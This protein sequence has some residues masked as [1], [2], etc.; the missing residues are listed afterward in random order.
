MSVHQQ[1]LSKIDS[2]CLDL[3]LHLRPDKCITL[4]FTDKRFD[5]KAHVDLL[6]GSTSNISNQPAKFL[7]KYIGSSRSSSL[8]PA[9][10]LLNNFKAS[11]A[12]I[13]KRS[14][15]GEYKLLIY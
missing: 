6:N 3:D 4:S 1:V 5:K 12:S 11:L 9:K 13:C 7:G 10:S 2:C 15:R 14:I 8:L